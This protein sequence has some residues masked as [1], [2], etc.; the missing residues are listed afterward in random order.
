MSVFHKGG[1]PMGD[2][3]VIRVGSL[4]KE[5]SISFPA[6]DPKAGE[7]RRFVS[8][9]T[10]GTYKEAVEA[11]KECERRGDLPY[12]VF[13]TD[14]RTVAQA[15]L[16]FE[17]TQESGKPFADA[18]HKLWKLAE[19]GHAPEREWYKEAHEL[20]ERIGRP[21][22]ETPQPSIVEAL[23][24][25]ARED[26]M[27]LGFPTTSI[28]GGA[29]ADLFT[30]PQI[31]VKP[32]Y[33]IINLSPQRIPPD[34]DPFA[35][36]LVRDLRSGMRTLFAHYHPVP[37]SLF[38]PNAFPFRLDM[39]VAN[40]GQMI[41]LSLT[42]MLP[43]AVTVNAVLMCETPKEQVFGGAR[44]EYGWSRVSVSDKRPLND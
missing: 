7:I 20:A 12:A 21:W 6:S 29:Q 11:K 17:V 38:A 10:P 14:P 13:S 19:E 26:L 37:G 35:G 36:L 28:A 15:T 22:H 2:H 24:R 5:R 9:E 18:V 40:V 31:L 27:P 34:Y 4:T 3:E 42:S 39:G 44:G 8:K 23:S 32:R 30:S 33:L 1:A 41:T 43:Y 16:K 25:A